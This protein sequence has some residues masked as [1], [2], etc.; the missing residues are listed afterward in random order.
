MADDLVSILRSKDPVNILVMVKRNHI[1]AEQHVGQIQI[2]DQGIVVLPHQEFLTVLVCGRELASDQR[3][4]F[5]DK[6]IFHDE[7]AQ[8]IEVY[9]EV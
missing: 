2:Q 5:F 1:R 9:P 8:R 6:V 7:V 3:I 4:K